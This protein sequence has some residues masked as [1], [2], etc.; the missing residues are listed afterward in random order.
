M[1]RNSVDKAKNWGYLIGALTP[2]I[3]A[4]DFAPVGLLGGIS[5]SI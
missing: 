4:R 3:Y 1:W 2:S 5:L